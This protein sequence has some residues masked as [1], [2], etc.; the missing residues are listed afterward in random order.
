MI[1]VI[2]VV[3]IIIIA[4]VFD[5]DFITDSPL[6]CLEELAERSCNCFSIRLSAN[7]PHDKQKPMEQMHQG[8]V[9]HTV[10]VQKLDLKFPGRAPSLV[11]LLVLAAEDVE[12]YV[13]EAEPASA[14]AT[15]PS[16]RCGLV[17]YC[18]MACTISP[19]EL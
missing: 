19:K 3:V 18:S 1:Q 7:C 14:H 2:I 9:V 10:F 17:G 8:R 6:E 11:L 12:M 5:L 15:K 4:W 13:P 16:W